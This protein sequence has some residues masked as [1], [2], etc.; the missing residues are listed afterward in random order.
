MP[1]LTPGTGVE[2]GAGVGKRLISGP[3]PGGGL[4]KT[5]RTPCRRA[6]VPAPVPASLQPPHVARPRRE[7]SP[8]LAVHG[9]APGAEELRTVQVGQGVIHGHP[10]RARRASAR[11][12]FANTIKYVLTGTSGNFGNMFSAAGASL[13]L[14]FLPMLPSHILLPGTPG[15][16]WCSPRRTNGY[17]GFSPL[18]AR[19]AASALTPASKRQPPPSLY[20]ARPGSLTQQLADALASPISG[21]NCCWTQHRASAG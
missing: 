13:F 16:T 18:S 19:P 20:R 2:R 14:S 7:W 5:P 8:L 10:G 12:P 21:C 1:V 9:E 17:C 11:R 15:A 3:S 6:G 4:Y